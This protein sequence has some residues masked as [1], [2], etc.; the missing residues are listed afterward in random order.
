M[1]YYDALIAK[2]PTVPGATEQDKLDNLNAEVVDGPDQLATLDPSTIIN[3]FDSAEYMTLTAMNL[4]QLTL[5]LSGINVD[6]SKN[7]NIRKII[8]AVFNGKTQTLANLQ[9]VGVKY[10]KSKIPWWQANGYTSTISHNDLV[11]AGLV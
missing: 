9:A 7:S 2:W 5:V 11:A 10:D 1:A 8:L 6:V 4:Q 3:A